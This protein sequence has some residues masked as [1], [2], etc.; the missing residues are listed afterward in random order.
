MLFPPLVV[1]NIAQSAYWADRT[2]RSELSQGIIAGEN[3]Y[4]SNLTSQFRRQINARALSGLRATSYL[5]KP[6]VERKIGADVCIILSNTTH[7]K[8]CVF[9]GKWPRLSTHR[10]CWDSVQKSSGLSHFDDQLL[11]Q[12]LVS[13]A[14]AVWEMFYCEYAFTKQPAFMLD[15]VSSC[16][17][18]EHA[19][20]ASQ[21]RPDNNIPWTDV[22]LSTL[23][24][25]H[26]TRIDQLIREVCACT[27][28]VLIPGRNYI[29][30]FEAYD[31]P[32]EVLILEYSQ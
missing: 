23:L 6:S 20:A 4:S 2:I 7:F 27:K 29:G 14:F 15:H 31:L 11:R 10:D 25:A 30:A 18:H 32:N 13:K 16:V 1:D 12:S 3:D 5:L 24:G 17:W 9:E 22:E 8:V 26:G 28:G 21:V 19:F